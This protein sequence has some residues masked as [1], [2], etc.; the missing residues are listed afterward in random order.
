MTP[1]TIANV[2]QSWLQV[3]A[4]WPQAGALFYANLFKADPTLKPL[5]S[6]DITQQ[7]TKLMQMIGAAVSKLDDL[8]ALRPILR[9]LG[10]RHAGYGVRH[11]HYPIVGAA[12]L[13]TLAQALG[14][15]FTPPLRA[16]WAEVYGVIAETMTATA[17]ADA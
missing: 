3:E 16:A 10:Q 11:A 7:G 4:L 8:D 13:Q 5:F 2:R 15:A 9:N 1:A 14:D 12:L 6:G 17:E